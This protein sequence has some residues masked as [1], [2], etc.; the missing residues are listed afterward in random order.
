MRENSWQLCLNHPQVPDSKNS[1][2]LPPVQPKPCLHS[3]S[4]PACSHPHPAPLL[5][6]PRPAPPCPGRKCQ[7]SGLF[8]ALVIASWDLSLIPYGLSSTELLGTSSQTWCSSAQ[9]H[10]KASCCLELRPSGSKRIHWG[11]EVPALPGPLSYGPRLAGSQV[12]ATG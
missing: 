7:T 12:S 2:V 1:S 11:L 6:L 8:K 10:S 9:E 3:L 5:L 4:A